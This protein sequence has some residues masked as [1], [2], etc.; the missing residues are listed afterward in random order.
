MEM[1][2]GNKKDDNDDDNRQTQHLNTVDNPAL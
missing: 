2:E 1:A